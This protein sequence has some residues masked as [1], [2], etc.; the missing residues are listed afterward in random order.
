M[1]IARMRQM[2]KVR[3]GLLLVSAF[4]T[5]GSAALAQ[6]PVDDTRGLV[7]QL[8]E[9]SGAM[10]ATAKACAYAS[11]EQLAQMKRDEMA[12][13]AQSGMDLSGYDKAFSR[14]HEEARAQWRSLSQVERTAACKELKEQL[15]A[16]AEK[17]NRPIR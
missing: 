10:H 8:A 4:A 12:F 3:I 7:D 13:H 2:I 15:S 14:G 9:F 11:D 5:V 16:A 1:E 17:L 6:Q